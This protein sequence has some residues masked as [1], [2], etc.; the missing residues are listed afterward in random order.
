M[1]FLDE[2]IAEDGK[3]SPLNV[4]AKESLGISSENANI[5]HNLNIFTVNKRF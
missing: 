4:R 3:I 2:T 1:T 5:R